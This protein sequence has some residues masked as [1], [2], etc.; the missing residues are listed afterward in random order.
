MTFKRPLPGMLE[1]VF[2]L[3][4]AAAPR[5]RGRDARGG[6]ACRPDPLGCGICDA[7]NVAAWRQG[8][9]VRCNRPRKSAGLPWATKRPPHA[10]RDGA[11]GGRPQDAVSEGQAVALLLASDRPAGAVAG[12]RLRVYL[13][14][15]ELRPRP[16]CSF[17]AAHAIKASPTG[18][19]GKHSRTARP[20][21][22]HHPLVRGSHSSFQ[23]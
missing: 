22:P 10:A 13:Q 3:R 23:P 16:C 14:R 4:R 6:I 12:C 9:A 17:R 18:P 21:W 1:R 8:N 5:T 19:G 20:Q 15:I 7:T 2:R 11:Q